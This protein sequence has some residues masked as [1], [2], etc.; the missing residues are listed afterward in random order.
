MIN[1]I[2]FLSQSLNWLIYRKARIAFFGGW[3]EYMRANSSPIKKL[4]MQAGAM[5]VAV[6]WM[7]NDSLFCMYR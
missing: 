6:D 4:H 7:D 3:M 5:V 2:A 1:V